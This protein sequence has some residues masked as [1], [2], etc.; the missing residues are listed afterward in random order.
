MVDNSFSTGE[1][2]KSKKLREL[3]GGNTIANNR[4][5]K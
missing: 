3:I 5:K 1:M 2:E 4:V